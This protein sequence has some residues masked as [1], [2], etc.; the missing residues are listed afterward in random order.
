MANLPKPAPAPPPRVPS[1]WVTGPPDFVGVGV[2]RAGTSRWFQLICS[3]PQVRLAPGA[4]KEIHFFDR[5]PVTDLTDADLARAYARHFPRPPGAVTGEWTPCYMGEFWGI[6][7]LKRAAPEARLLVILRD[8]IDR[9]ASAIARELRRSR[10]TGVP[11]R[12]GDFAIAAG[13]SRYGEQLERVF[14]HFDRSQVLIMQYE[15][16]CADPHAELAR[17][18]SFLGLEDPGLAVSPSDDRVNHAGRHPDLDPTM[19]EE[20]A[21]I[22]AP[23]MER[24]RALLPDLDYSLWTSWAQLTGSR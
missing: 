13:R 22:L 2:Q 9:F 21:A 24:L 11:V 7:N 6:A 16:T 23:D 15:R 1:G 10:E 4:P 12:P 8:P 20:L 5:L 19:L 14:A 18:W 17:T 3:H